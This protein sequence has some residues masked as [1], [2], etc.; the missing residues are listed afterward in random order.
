MPSSR[1]M[2]FDDGDDI[3]PREKKAG[4]PVAVWV[5]GAAATITLILAGIAVA[6]FYFRS[7]SASVATIPPSIK[8][9]PPKEKEG[10]ILDS[11]PRVDF[12]VVQ[13]EY[14]DNPVAASAR[15]GKGVVVA[16]YVGRIQ[17]EVMGISVG[18]SAEPKSQAVTFRV[19]SQLAR[20]NVA[21]VKP[22]QKVKAVVIFYNATM[23]T[24]H[25][26]EAAN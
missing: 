26:V 23:G 1:R 21:R 11:L 5:V 8:V 19:T 18:L 4:V 9:A 15:Y 20:E 6:Y 3:L 17:R 16:G 22:G 14:A 7:D 13:K 12:A 10:D 25:L 2:R 24:L